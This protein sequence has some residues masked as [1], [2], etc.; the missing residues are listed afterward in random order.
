MAFIVDVYNLGDVTEYEYKFVGRCGAKGE[1]RAVRKKATPEQM[2]SQNHSNKVKRVRRE[3]QLNFKPWDLWLT[4]KY[5]RGTRKYS[6]EVLSDFK[7]WAGRMRRAYRKAG[8]AFKWIRRIEI[9]R[10]GGI[11]VH[12][13]ANRPR[14]IKNADLLI[15]ELWGRGGVNFQTLKDEGGYDALAEYICKGGDDEIEGQLS[16]LPDEE[17]KRCLRYSTSRNL[18]RPEDVRERKKYSHWTMKRMLES[19]PEPKE[20]YYIDKGSIRTGINPYTGWSWYYYA[21]RRIKAAFET[22]ACAAGMRSVKDRCG[23]PA[24]CD[25]ARAADGRRAKKSLRGGE[26]DDYK[27]GRRGK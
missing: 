12:V 7:E 6:N 19:G 13:L 5:K 24:P 21:E 14:S 15:K 26:C 2:K 1:K 25:A 16:L 22:Y 10:Y 11:H 17:R 3:I 9:G 8:E 20:G 23:P 27:D 4:L 18:I